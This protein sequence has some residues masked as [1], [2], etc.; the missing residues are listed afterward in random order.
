L[1]RFLN[2]SQRGL[3]GPAFQASSKVFINLRFSST[4][5]YLTDEFD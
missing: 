4:L 3:P 5:V 1:C 2:V